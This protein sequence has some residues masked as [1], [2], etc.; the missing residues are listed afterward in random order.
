[1]ST[2]LVPIRKVNGGEAPSVIQLAGGSTISADAKGRFWVT[3]AVAGAL[4]LQGFEVDHS[5]AR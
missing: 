2:G 4:R 1:M 3:P 5:E